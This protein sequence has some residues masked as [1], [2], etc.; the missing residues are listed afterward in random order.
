MV[1]R[2]ASKAAAVV[3]VG[4]LL[5]LSFSG[6]VSDDIPARPDPGAGDAGAGPRQ[7]ASAPGCG[8]IKL[9]VGSG[10]LFWT[11]KATGAV[12]SVPTTGGSTTVIATNQ[13]S[14]GPIAVDATSVFWVNGGNK[15]IMKKALA[16]GAATVFVVATTVGEVLGGENDI[17][18]LLVDK[19]T[20]YFGRYIYALKVPT[21]GG[22]MP[23]VIGRSPE[24][25]VGKPGAFAIDATHLYQTELDHLAVTRETLD[26]N[27]MGLLEGRM[28]RQPLAPDRIGISRAGLLLDAIAVVSGNVIWADN[29]KIETM[30]VD[31]LENESLAAIATS[32][33]YNPITGVVVSGTTI[34]LGESSNNNVE[35]APLP[36]NP[37]PDAGAPE[38]TV[39]ATNQMSPSQFAADDTNIYWR[40][41]DCRI[42]KLA[43]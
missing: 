30:P 38:A 1:R 6:C 23:K 9:V 24:S 22:M 14:P 28:T 20:L 26:G 11:E 29:N 21:N 17:N 31:A 18:A 7:L 3:A 10:T 35:S 33:G 8:S 42:M 5:G 13:M 40:T 32:A 15:T 37:D 19:G 12:K 39:I 4:V 2:A 36:T 41:A 25:D 16:G 27:Q 34:Y 43:K